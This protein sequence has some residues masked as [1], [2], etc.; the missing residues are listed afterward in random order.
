MRRD[1][2]WLLLAILLVAA[3]LLRIHRLGDE[4]WL[5]EIL[6]QIRVSR[7]GLWQLATTYESQNQHLLYSLLARL[8]IDVLGDTVIAL[9]AP[10]AICGVL[11]IAATFLVGRELLSRR[12]ALVAAAL[13]AFSDLHV[14][15]SQN[16][17][18]YTALALA[19]LPVSYTHLTLPTILRV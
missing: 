12:E 4:T 11:S 15:F 8:S 16:A 3:V 1:P 9:R 2:T 10:A 17:R 7:L 14:W 19:T 6:T 5:D 18:G 13:L